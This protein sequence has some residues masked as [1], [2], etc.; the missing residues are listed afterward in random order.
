MDGMS[1]NGIVWCG[2]AWH[3]VAWQFSMMWYCLVRYG[4]VWDGKGYGM[5]WYGVWH[6]L[7][8]DGMVCRSRGWG[9]G[10]RARGIGYRIWDAVPEHRFQFTV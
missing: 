1:S 3:S 7:V 9:V 10:Y 6:V 5:P 2:V 4:A 8:S